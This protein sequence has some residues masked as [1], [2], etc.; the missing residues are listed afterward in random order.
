MNGDLMAQ[1]E[2]GLLGSILRDNSNW[3]HTAEL[4]STDFSLS[5]HT[6]IYGCMAAMFA[7]GR[8]VDTFS[9]S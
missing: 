8:T 2:R 1:N 4:A 9:L 6:V 3:S 5:N 7:D